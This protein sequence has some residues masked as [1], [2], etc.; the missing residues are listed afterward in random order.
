MENGNRFSLKFAPG[1]GADVQ[2]NF[3]HQSGSELVIN[4]EGTVQ[5]IDMMGRII[6]D[7]DMTSNNRIDISKFNKTAYI[8]RLINNEGVNTQ[9]IVVY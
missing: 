4:A 3:V 1:K 2:D 6:Y 7:N 9:K 8:V 5:I